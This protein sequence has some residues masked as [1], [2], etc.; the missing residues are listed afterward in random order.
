MKELKNIYNINYVHDNIIYSMD[1]LRLKTLITFNQF[2]KIE[3]MIKTVYKDKIKNFWI[4]DRVMQFKYNYVIEVE[5]GKTIYFGFMHNNEKIRFDKIDDLFNFT[6]EFNPNKLKDNGL[7]MYLLD[8]SSQ[9]YIKS[10]DIAFD[11]KIS[12]L[13]LITDMSG[14][15]IEKIDNRGYDNKTICIGKGDGRL[16]IYNKKKES[17]LNI[18][19]DMTRI[20][21][22]REVEDFEVR[23]IKLFNYDNNFPSVYINNYV[24]SLSDYQ[25]KTLLALLYAV[26]NGFPLRDL[27]KTYRKKIKDLLEGG[28][29]IKFS[30]KIVTDLIRQTIFFY[31]IRKDRKN[32]IIWW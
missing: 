6:I 21:I 10:Y 16:K 22:S 20:E 1:M 25:D 8:I 5:E 23:K 3:F 32:S 26:Q 19:G 2:S 11:V 29:K 24:Y 13:D 30:N 28:Y 7:V 17:D 9:W 31:F 14:R 18:V 12:I 4:S 15:S 27:T